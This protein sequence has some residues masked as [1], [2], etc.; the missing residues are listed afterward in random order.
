[1]WSDRIATVFRANCA[2]LLI[3]DELAGRLE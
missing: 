3:W 1:L 2:T